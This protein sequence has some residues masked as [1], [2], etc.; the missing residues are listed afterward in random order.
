MH[1]DDTKKQIS[2]NMLNF[3][4]HSNAYMNFS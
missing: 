4:V 1:R 2:C 3:T